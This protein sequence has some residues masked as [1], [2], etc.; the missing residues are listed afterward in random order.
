MLQAMDSAESERDRALEEQK[1]VME[2]LKKFVFG[3]WG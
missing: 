2:Q 1:V 3:A